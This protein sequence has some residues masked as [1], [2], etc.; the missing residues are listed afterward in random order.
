M[1]GLAVAGVL[2]CVRFALDP[3]R[4]APERVRTTAAGLSDRAAEGFA[5]LF[6]RDYLTWDSGDP[7]AHES[8]LAPFTGSDMEAEAGMRLVPDGRQRVEWTQV[9]QAREA[10][11]GGHAYTLAAQTDTS[12]LLYLSVTVLREPNGRLALGS[13]PAFVAAPSFTGAALDSGRPEV[14]DSSLRTVL[15]RALRNY[16]AGARGELAADLAAGVSA[17]PPTLKLT[18]ESI[19]ALDWGSGGHSVTAVVLAHDAPGTQYRLAYEVGVVSRAGRW[20]ITAIQ[21]N[22]ERGEPK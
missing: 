10:I 16:L 8:A 15:G 3:P 9:V 12:G 20:E 6:A 1:N 7:Q 5:S 22:Q 14:E 11:G 18:L 19:D 4:V 13:Y 2:A 21:A 17:A